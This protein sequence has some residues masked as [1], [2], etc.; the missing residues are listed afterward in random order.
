M[1]HQ[2]SFRT[3]A[4][5]KVNRIFNE[6]IRCRPLH[7]PLSRYSPHLSTITESPLSTLRRYSPVAIPAR[8]RRVIDTADIDVSTPRILSGQDGNQRN[9]LRRDR[10][11]I[12]IRCQALK[13]NPA[14][15]QHN[16]RH[17]KSVGELLVEKFLIKDK[18]LE[19]ENE[20]KRRQQRLF[21]QI[22]L[23]RERD[24]EKQEKKEEEEEEEEMDEERDLQ[25][26]KNKITRR[27]TR[28]RSSADIQLDAEQIE[29]KVAYAQVQ[30][31]V[32]DSL[33]AEEQ[34]E[35]ENEVRRGTLIK[36]GRKPVP[37]FFRNVD[38]D[39]VSQ[40]EEEAAAQKMRKT[41]KK[42]KKRKKTTEKPS[43]PE[44]NEDCSRLCQSDVPNNEE[45]IEKSNTFNV[46][47]NSVPDF[48]AAVWNGGGVEQFRESVRIPIPKKV[49]MEKLDKRHIEEEK[50]EEE[51]ERE[52]EVVLPVKKPYV[53]DTS[54]NSV[55]F[56]V[57]TPPEA[58]TRKN[59]PLKKFEIS[60]KSGEGDTIN[61]VLPAKSI[62][63]DGDKIIGKQKKTVGFAGGT[64][65]E[66]STMGKVASKQ[67][68]KKTIDDGPSSR[69]EASSVTPSVDP[70]ASESSA[71]EALP[72]GADRL[73]KASKIN[74]DENNAVEAPKR[75]LRGAQYLANPTK[76][77][78][79]AVLSDLSG[80]V[81]DE[82]VTLNATR[83]APPG[84]KTAG[85]IGEPVEI[86]GRD[87]ASSSAADDAT[88]QLVTEK[89]IILE[90]IEGDAQKKEP[91]ID[92]VD[93]NGREEVRGSSIDRKMVK[94][95]ISLLELGKEKKVEVIDKEAS[96]RGVDIKIEDKESKIDNEPA[97]MTMDQK[98]LKQFIPVDENKIEKMVNGEKFESL[99]K[100]TS[101]ESIDFWSEIKGPDSPKSGGRLS[102]GGF[103]FVDSKSSGQGVEDLGGGQL[104]KK[105]E[106]E[107][108]IS[109]ASPPTELSNIHVIHEEE[110]RTE[111]NS[112]KSKSE[113]LSSIR[114]E[115][116]KGDSAIPKK[117]RLKKKKNL[118]I[119]IN[120]AQTEAYST[121]KKALLKREDSTVSSN[122]VAS[123]PDTSVPASEVST[124][125]AEISLPV[126]NI[127]NVSTSPV[128]SLL[129]SQ[130]LDEE[131]EPKTPTN[132]WADVE[133]Q[134][135]ISKWND[136]NVNSVEREVVQEEPSKDTS[137][138]TSPE[139]S[140]ESSKKKKVVRK[141]KSS[142]I[143]KSSGKKE[144]GKDSGKKNASGK[145]SCSSKGQEISKP[146]EANSCKNSPKNAPSQR[147]LDLIRMFYTTPSA[148]LTATPRD[149]SKVRRA[150]IKRRKHHSRTPSVSSDS[151]GSTTSTATTESSGST[152][153]ELD[154]DPEHKRMNST[155]SNDSGFDGSP[156]ISST[157]PIFGSFVPCV[158]CYTDVA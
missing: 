126:I 5:V 145:K 140:P 123:T 110:R 141:K 103:S 3:L 157:Y 56:T 89:K 98:S 39:S 153:T 72:S 82:A 25:Q 138:N 92:E 99:S 149:L 65:L 7:S 24:K 124:P 2:R 81:V 80:N 95:D 61:R 18:K 137:V 9:R 36:K 47:S 118:S 109:V 146:V 142:T 74:T 84:G 139:G 125:I 121:V 35:I 1:C 59:D 131:D 29:R 53:K 100:S 128:N 22:S 88:E 40:S 4:F 42:M 54:R 130:I 38:G 6:I 19:E 64:K 97:S 45:E 91:R 58:A 26:V 143:K 49:P 151:T 120:Q 101:S 62:P 63:V 107:A 87:D 46:E 16:E 147:P 69:I 158:N 113:T 96:K 41:L 10:P 119:N 55:Y 73:P 33:V 13:D 132:E 32:L 133:S 106:T 90:G 86:L 48:S 94:L 155:R 66:E 93:E 102:N 27:F 150:K 112:S 144:S 78:D 117:E 67:K 85:R 43:P 57:K 129:D 51:E 75:V 23:D 114:L 115:L 68:K 28:R 34:A 50:E 70:L 111:E 116:D 122:S 76:A 83:A 108:K 77:E 52:Y 156:R 44:T 104:E 21:H 152:C 20:K 79:V 31:K 60:T 154:D 17:E 134:S 105:K 135:K 127:E 11:T 14:L 136:E 37:G 15:R 12:K 30:A 8:S 71:G 148:L